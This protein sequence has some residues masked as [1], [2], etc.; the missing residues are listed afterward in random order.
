MGAKYKFILLESQ[1]N[2]KGESPIKLRVILNRKNTLIH[3]GLEISAKDWNAEKE[4]IRRTDPFFIEKNNRL[5]SLLNLA[6]ECEKIL[7]DTKPA[8]N[9][10]DVSGL[11]RSRLNGGN[12]SVLIKPFFER[13]IQDKNFHDKRTI[14]SNLN[15]I[16]DHFG[17]NVGFAAI[18]K[19]GLSGFVRDQ[20]KKGKS[21]ETVKK[22]I[23][24]LKFV[25]SRAL[26][27]EIIKPFENVF[28]K[29]LELPF[30]KR[31]KVRDIKLS[32]EEIKLLI[33][34]EPDLKSEREAL[35]VFIFQFLAQGMRISDALTLKWTNIKDGVL[36][37]SSNKTGTYFEIVLSEKELSIIE[38]YRAGSKR[39]DFI[40][41]FLRKRSKYGI[42]RAIMNSTA[43]INAL[44]KEISLKAGIDKE[45]A[46]RISSHV[47][48]HSFA[49]LIS[50]NTPIQYVQSML[51]H[52]NIQ[53]TRDYIG[54]LRPDRMT[55]FKK[56]LFDSL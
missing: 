5:K 3:S 32:L 1:I 46:G 31:N 35:D 6:Y 4:E 14:I 7:F 47:A 19:E 23:N 11:I 33:E 50:E 10:K 42:E 26:K 25:Y 49:F 13:L 22:Y 44:L 52:S 17:E 53:Q 51:G 43:Q 16:F 12:E 8:F 40:F 27:A 24:K 41:P 55:D 45:K 20:L 28:L 34:F 9:V 56:G 21:T 39:S 2:A 15:I 38:R 37:Y 29:E 30:P 36:S 18:T 48:R 54:R